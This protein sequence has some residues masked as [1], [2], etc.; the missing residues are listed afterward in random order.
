MWKL[1][2]GPHKN[3][4]Q[5][6]GTRVPRGKKN[7]FSLLRIPFH[8]VSNVWREEG[9][10]GKR[11]SCVC[12]SCFFFFYIAT[13]FIVH[14]IFFLG[15]LLILLF[16]ILVVYL[17]FPKTSTGYVKHIVSFSSCQGFFLIVIIVF[18]S[19]NIPSTVKQ[20]LGIKA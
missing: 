14:F 7:Y 17:C 15:N 1:N 3:W 9:R 6:Q 13:G 12:L 19:I 16:F 4:E 11:K 20:D 2:H 5:L 10:K 8:C 18:S